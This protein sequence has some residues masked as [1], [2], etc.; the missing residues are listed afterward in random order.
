CKA[1]EIVSNY[2]AVSAGYNYSLISH[3]AL[4]PT[5]LLS[6]WHRCQHLTFHNMLPVSKLEKT[7]L[8]SGGISI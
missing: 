3:T 4:L 8:L 1:R 5:W 2:N 7:S 6:I